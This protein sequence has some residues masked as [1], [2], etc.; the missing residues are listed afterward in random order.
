MTRIVRALATFCAVAMPVFAATAADPIRLEVGGYY[1]GVAAVQS[2]MRDRSQPVSTRL[3][4][5]GITYEGEL[6]FRGVAKLDNGWEVGV[7]IELEAWS[8]P[9][10]GD[11]L[12]EEFIFVRTSHGEVQFGATDGAA[13]KLHVSLPTAA[14]MHG[15]DDPFMLAIRQPARNLAVLGGSLAGSDAPNAGDST[16]IT[17][18]SPTW[19]GI[20]VGISY[21]PSYS[22]SAG[23]GACGF[24]GGGGA[25]G[26]CPRNGGQWVNGVEA[27]MRYAGVIGAVDFSASV[28]GLRARFDGGPSGVAGTTQK[29]IGAGVNLGWR[30][31]TLGAAIMADNQGLRGDYDL[32]Q[33]GVA[34]TYRDGRWVYGVG[35]TR[36][37]A[38]TGAPGRPDRAVLLDVS[39]AYELGPGIV[40]FGGL[41]LTRS[42]SANPANEGKG[43]ALYAGSRLTF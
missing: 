6:H 29:R 9:A 17:Y 35:F 37:S 2:K 20:G 40:L 19:R 21:T 15:V 23:P 28:G 31:V 33:W 10:G 8:Q 18:L 7:R 1:A 5:T 26:V 3:R 25:A 34:A 24:R 32:L 39:A 38:G 41:Q 43:G 16:K 36:V 12:D 22:P 13:Y 27:A 14:P 11:Q 30:G 42:T 4:P